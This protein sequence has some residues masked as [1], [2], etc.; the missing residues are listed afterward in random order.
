[1]YVLVE[2]VNK[3]YIHNKA[4]FQA[5]KDVNLEIGRG[6]FVCILGPSGCGK[7]TLLSLMAGFERPTSGTVRIGGK[8]VKKPS[9]Q[10]LTIF[11]NHNLLPWRTL[12]KN[13]ELGLEPLKLS[14]KERNER[15]CKYID[16][17]GLG[18]FLKN[19]PYQLSGGMCQRVAF[20]GV[21]A[22]NPDIIFM[23]EPFGA[24][25]AL[26]RMEMQDEILRLQRKEEK[27]IVFV[28]HD[29]EEAIFLADKVVVM[30]PGP[31]RIKNIIPVH[32]GEN[33]DRTAGDFLEIRDKVFGEFELKRPDTTEYFI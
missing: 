15:A 6:E 30:S 26:T 4:E 25:D 22:A 31:G 27:T 20:A 21:L 29:I 19:H 12:Q 8:E 11:Q 33:R 9:S 24:L 5:L 28:T 23:D 16:L 10:Y 1:M 14:K 17:V 2:N 32:L 18:A 13:V 7:S 3:I